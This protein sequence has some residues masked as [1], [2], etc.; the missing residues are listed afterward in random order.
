[1]SRVASAGVDEVRKEFIHA[2]GYAPRLFRSPGRINLIGEHVDYNHGFVMPAAVSR[3]LVLAA[4][5]NN[6]NK[7]RLRS[8]AETRLHEYAASDLKPTT[9]WTTYALGIVSLLGHGRKMEGIDLVVSGDI[10]I[11][12]GMSSS[13]ALT[14]GFAYAVDALL[15]LRIDKLTLAK[16][17]QEVEHSF[18]GVRC[19]LMDPYAILFSQSGRVLLLDCLNESHETIP[20][21]AQQAELL[22]VDTGVKH[23]LESSE[24]N[25]RRTA[26]EEA[27]SIIM[28]RSP[29]VYTWRDV[30][31][32]MIEGLQSER[33]ESYPPARFVVEEISR[34]PE[35]AE[36]LKQ[37]DIGRLGELMYKAH[38]GLRD[39][40]KVSCSELDVLVGAAGNIPD[41]LGSRMMGGGFGGC[42]INLVGV[43]RSEAVG[44]QLADHFRE[45]FGRNPAI[46]PVTIAGG[47]SELS[48]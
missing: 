9:D 3:Q 11:G 2:F 5:V 17:A 48:V 42:T 33:A 10:P 13:A 41:V 29:E 45:S 18:A 8:L 30:D 25:Q 26:C 1:M 15:D 24:Y 16:T 21:P 20:F 6:V 38:E 40:Y 28:K 31:S 44:A 27:L 35:A 14:S 39:L 4:G 37:G 32:Q 36:A 12:A 19:G 23:S 22:L 34:A 46:Y 47:V 43:G 7:I